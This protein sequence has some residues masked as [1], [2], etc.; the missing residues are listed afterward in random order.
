MNK[1]VMVANLCGSEA[2]WLNIYLVLVGTSYYFGGMVPAF[3]LSTLNI[4]HRETSCPALHPWKTPSRRCCE[5]GLPQSPMARKLQQHPRAIL[6][7]Y[8][9]DYLHLPPPVLYLSNIPRAKRT[10]YIYPILK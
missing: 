2:C 9:S 5:R 4:T 8:L 1:G 6:L 3:R 10:D 7:T